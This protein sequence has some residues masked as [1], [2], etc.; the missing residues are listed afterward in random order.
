MRYP[1]IGL[2]LHGIH[3]NSID[4]E[5]FVHLELIIMALLH[6]FQVNQMIRQ[7]NT[8]ADANLSFGTG[9][10]FRDVQMNEQNFGHHSEHDLL[11]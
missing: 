2:V 10:A 6:R 3:T 5:A 4:I 8:L 11:D 9:A 7:V 1:S